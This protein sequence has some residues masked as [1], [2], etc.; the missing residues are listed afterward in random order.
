MAGGLFH[1][2]GD[3]LVSDPIG[4]GPA[5]FSKQA[6][7]SLCPVTLSGFCHGTIARPISR[8]S[9]GLWLPGPAL[10]KPPWLALAS[11]SHSGNL[12][13]LARLVFYRAHT[14][15]EYSCKRNRNRCPK[16]SSD[17]TT[18]RYSDRTT[19]SPG[20]DWHFVWAGAGC[21]SKNPGTSPATG[22]SK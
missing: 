20:G 22:L 16:G 7:F 13:L 5:L 4:S 10:S 15:H 3:P 8:R 12:L 14:P 21:G 6:R 17:S 11:Y 1:R 9:G 18:G 19:R 2:L